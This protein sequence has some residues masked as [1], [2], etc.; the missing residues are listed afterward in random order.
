MSIEKDMFANV[1]EFYPYPI[2]IF[3]FD[4]TVRLINKAAFE[5]IGLKNIESHLGKYSIFKDPIIL[6]LGFMEQVKKVLNGENVYIPNLNVPYQTIMKHFNLVDRD[7]QTISSDITCFPLI[8][9][10]DAMEYFV[11]IFIIKEIYKGK[12]EID[13]GK[14]YIE[15]N[16][17]NPFDAD[18]AAEAACLSKVHFTKLFKKYLGMT[19]HEYYINFKVNKLKEK[20]LDSNLSITQAFSACGLDYN[21]YSAK[22]YREKV[23]EIVDI[24]K[25]DLIDSFQLGS[26]KNELL[27]KVIDLFPYPIQVYALDGTSVVVNKAILNEYHI[28][29]PYEIVGK[30]NIFKDPAVIETGQI[31]MVRRAFKGEIVSFSGIRVPLD[32]IRERYDIKDLDITAVYQD[33]ILYP[34]IDDMKEVRYI[35]VTLINRRV[36]RGKDEIEAAKEYIENNWQKDFDS[37]AIARAACLSKAHFIKLFKKH[38][39]E[40]P[41]EYYI[42]YKIEKVKE[43]LLDSNI[44]ITQAFE[45]C[46]I[47]YN[48]YHAKVFKNKVGYSPSKY[49]KI[50]SGEL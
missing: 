11:A 9:S 42:N 1:I 39:G 22:L 28:S 14:Q 2:Q 47:N 50:F 49:R 37:N 7:I 8:N 16:W 35:V 5:M 45:E 12:K 24:I 13:W 40:T 4:G 38:T 34:I 43:R 26:G 17:Q 44:S 29:N 10:N 31:H 20:I 33:I 18:K 15:A 41:H 19:P 32:E 23:R 46:N 3:S 36:Y 30:Y 48:G 21:S 25:D 27:S 6:E